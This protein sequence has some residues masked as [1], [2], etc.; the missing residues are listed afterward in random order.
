M[1]LTLGCWTH[2]NREANVAELAG[3]GTNRHLAEMLPPGD[4]SDS[5]SNT[6]AQPR[7][8]YPVNL[9]LYNPAIIPGNTSY[10]VLGGNW[11]PTTTS[12]LNLLIESTMLSDRR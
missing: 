9:L 10:A 6:T 5:C 2:Q 1:S 11:P 12:L 7:W 3:I 8:G 4:S